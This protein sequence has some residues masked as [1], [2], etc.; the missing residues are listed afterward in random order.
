MATQLTLTQFALLALLVAPTAP[1]GRM[2]AGHQRHSDLLLHRHHRLLA[3]FTLDLFHRHHVHHRLQ[4]ADHDLV[5]AVLSGNGPE[6]LPK[7]KQYDCRHRTRSIC[8]FVVVTNT[9]ICFF[10]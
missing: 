6:V 2:S 1:S 5:Y 9:P 4:S 7:A 8:D 3:V 10:Q